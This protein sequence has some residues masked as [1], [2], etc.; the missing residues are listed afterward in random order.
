MRG[1]GHH[2]RGHAAL[3]A[4]KLNRDIER[5][6]QR[7]STLF[8]SSISAVVE[9]FVILASHFRVAYFADG[10]TIY[11]SK[12]AGP[13]SSRIISTASILPRRSVV[14]QGFSAFFSEPS[15]FSCTTC[16]IDRLCSDALE[17]CHYGMT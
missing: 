1:C 4:L 9:G 6:L 16:M 17:L 3:H 7:V 12:Q 2:V 5:E 8:P 14:C 15:L 11:A 13:K 10:H